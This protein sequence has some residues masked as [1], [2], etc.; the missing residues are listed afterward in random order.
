MGADAAC[1]TGGGGTD[2]EEGGVVITGGE[3]E[4]VSEF[5]SLSAAGVLVAVELSASSS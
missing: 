4:R 5:V 2:I 1:I 3:T